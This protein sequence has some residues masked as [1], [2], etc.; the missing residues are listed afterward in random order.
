MLVVSPAWAVGSPTLAGDLF[1]RELDDRARRSALAI[2][3]LRVMIGF[4]VGEPTEDGFQFEVVG[5]IIVHPPLRRSLAHAVAA[6]SV[7]GAGA[8]ICDDLI[9]P[10][11]YAVA[12]RP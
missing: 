7:H 3:A 2:E 11:A 4:L 12:E 5:L 8:V 6:E 9:A 1:D 10:L